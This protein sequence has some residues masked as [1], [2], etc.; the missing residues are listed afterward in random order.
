M[1]T[2]SVDAEALRRLEE[3]PLERRNEVKGSLLLQ[4]GVLVSPDAEL[5]V[6]PVDEASIESVARFLEGR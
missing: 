3:I 4:L 1:S 6:P 2:D 5:A